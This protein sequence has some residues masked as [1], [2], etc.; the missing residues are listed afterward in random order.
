MMTLRPTP[1]QPTT[2]TVA[3]GSTLAAL[4]AAPTPVV[5]QQPITAALSSPSSDGQGMHDTSGTTEYWEKQASL[6][7]GV[8]FVSPLCSLYVPS[9]IVVDVAMWTSHRL[10]RPMVQKWHFPHRDTKDRITGSPGFR[11]VM[12]GP[13]SCTTPEP[14]WPSTA[15]RGMDAAPC[16]KCQSLRQMPAAPIF[17]STSLSFGGSS[18]NSS[19]TNG[20]FASYSTAAFVFIFRSFLI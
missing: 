15:G 19:I 18:S 16:M 10:G 4:T 7:M 17:T 3:P 6:A 14:S 13:T 1:P 11:D 8:T 20:V 9:I 5:T 12:P 2:A